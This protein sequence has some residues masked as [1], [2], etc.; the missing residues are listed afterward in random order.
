MSKTP[1]SLHH[2]LE[3]IRMQANWNLQNTKEKMEDCKVVRMDG[4]LK[5]FWIKLSE[6]S[7]LVKRTSEWWL[8]AK[9][10]RHCTSATATGTKPC[11]A[12]EN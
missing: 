2:E 11:N 6:A 7:H 5:D 10:L 9:D 12:F 4:G 3:W 8:S 1:K